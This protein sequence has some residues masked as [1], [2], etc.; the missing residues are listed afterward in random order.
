LGAPASLT[1]DHDSAN[2]S[3]VRGRPRRV[4]KVLRSRIIGSDS[5]GPD[6]GPSIVLS[7]SSENTTTKARGKKSS[8]NLN[9]SVNLDVDLAN[10]VF[11]NCPSRLA[12][13]DVADKDV[14]DL[15]GFVGMAQRYGA[16]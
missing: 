9:L 3:D 2:D 6:A 14:D 8:V 10:L 7:D 4:H 16:N 15:A 12:C 5:D 11:S 13:E 1:I